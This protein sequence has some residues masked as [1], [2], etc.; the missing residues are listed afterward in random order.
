[1]TSNKRVFIA[2]LLIVCLCL[3]LVACNDS[4]SDPQTPQD[5]YDGTAVIRLTAIGPTTIK[6]QNRTNKGIGYGYG[7]KGRRVL[8]KRRNDCYGQRKRT[9]NGT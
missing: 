1:M 9:C 8:F 6:S 5:T 3:A 7:E 4:P 2:L